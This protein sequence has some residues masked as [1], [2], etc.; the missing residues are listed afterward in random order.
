MHHLVKIIAN[1]KKEPLTTTNTHAQ[2]Y[3]SRLL[4]LFIQNCATMFSM[5]S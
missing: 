3:L 5:Y 1:I 2:Y 4:V